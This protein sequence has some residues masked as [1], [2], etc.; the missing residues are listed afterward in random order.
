MSNLAGASESLLEAW[1]WGPALGRRGDAERARSPKQRG[2]GRI[3]GVGS[4][5]GGLQWA[6]RVALS[7]RSQLAQGLPDFISESPLFQETPLSPKMGMV[8]CP[9]TKLFS[10]F[11]VSEPH[12]VGIMWRWGSN[13]GLPC[14]NLHSSLGAASLAVG[15][16]GQPTGRSL[17]RGHLAEGL[18]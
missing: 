4:Q 5:V 17:Q 12:P 1:R 13:P 6:E 7:G 18:G 11:F 8:R 16:L 2:A 15:G 10:L 14:A 9:K 3:S